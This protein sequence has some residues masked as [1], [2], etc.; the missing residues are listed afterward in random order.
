[1]LTYNYHPIKLIRYF[2]QIFLIEPGASLVYSEHSEP[3][4][5]TVHQNSKRHLFPN[6]LWDICDLLGLKLHLLNDVIGLVFIEV[7]NVEAL[8]SE[9]MVAELGETLAQSKACDFTLVLSEFIGN[10]VWAL[11]SKPLVG[12]FF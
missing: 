9:N 8:F 2:S 7:A 10:L 5:L 4:V 3:I 1:M 11:G 12:P 6:E